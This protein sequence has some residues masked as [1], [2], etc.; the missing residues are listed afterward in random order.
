MVSAMFTVILTVIAFIFWAIVGV[1]GLVLGLLVAF[2]M[3][4]WPIGCYDKSRPQDKYIIPITLVLNI[5]CIIML[6]MQVID[7]YF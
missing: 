3:L 1:I 7:K 2:Y 4:F 6:A 5:T